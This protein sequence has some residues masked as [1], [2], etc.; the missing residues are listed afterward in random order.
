[1][2]KKKDCPHIPL[3]CLQHADFGGLI[4]FYPTPTPNSTVRQ[5]HKHI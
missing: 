4:Q 5:P 1:M 2:E 3:E